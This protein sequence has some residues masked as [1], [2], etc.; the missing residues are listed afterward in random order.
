MSFVGK[1]IV[2]KFEPKFYYGTID[3]VKANSKAECRFYFHIIYDDDD[4]EDMDMSEVHQARALYESME[5][6]NEGMA[7]DKQMSMMF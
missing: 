4:Q 5:P 6:D 2:K 3:Y 1:R 7:M